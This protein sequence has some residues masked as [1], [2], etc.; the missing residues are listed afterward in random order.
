MLNKK[1]SDIWVALSVIACSVVLFIALA[2]GLSG[3]SFAPGGN[4]LRVRFHDVTGIKIS[5]HVKYAGAPAG[6][7]S[8]LRILTTG[9]RTRDPGN[10]VEMTLTLLPEVPAM[11]KDAEISIAADTLL[12]DKFVLIS[13]GSAAA[14]PAG[15]DDVLQGI[16]PTTFDELARNTDNA[17]EGLRRT[18]GGGVN[19]T[20]DIITRAQKVLE[21]V[22]AI[23]SDFRPI[24]R[25]AAATMANTK[26]TAAD[27]RELLADNKIRIQKTMEKLDSAT[28][29]IESLAKRGESL[30]R[31][32]E[33]NLGRTLADFRI[34]AE[35][36]KVTS[37]Y[38]KFL[39]NDLA[40]HPS[41]LIWG[42]G[43]TPAMPSE[44]QILNR[45]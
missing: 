37:T 8:G 18:L 29:A 41:R 22:E 43:K 26:A 9:E 3:G 7:V 13:Q 28:T 4:L 32:N 5:S 10:M 42:T 44:Q 14:A 19:G 17:I 6:R 20:Q 25:D 27:A 15:P 23:L 2:L 12:S 30:I 1:T 40:K 39:L 45:R 24:V 11:T 21:N 35:N 16:E 36:L 33:K 38:S 31:D 34:T